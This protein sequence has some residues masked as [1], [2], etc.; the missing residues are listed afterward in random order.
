M[1]PHAGTRQAEDSWFRRRF[2]QSPL[3][4]SSCDLDGVLTDVNEAFCR[5]VGRAVDELVGLPS[6]AL[7]HRSDSGEADAQ[8]DL[9]LRGEVDRVRVE[10]ILAGP[11]GRP[12]P[13][14]VDTSLLRDDR[15]H[16]L[17]AA[18]F[19]Q[20]LTSLRGVERRRQQQEDFFLALAQRASDLAIVSDAE[21]RVLYASPALTR[22]LGY[23]AE[24]VLYAPATE[25]LHD[26]D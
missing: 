15:G 25:F 19:V 3:P 24:D 4:Q 2:E 9:L 7:S 12:V 8:L 16:P 26:D 1:N 13:S 18:A 20:D 10:R 21:G 6:T 14:L 11:H 5:L 22:M 23:G 17:G